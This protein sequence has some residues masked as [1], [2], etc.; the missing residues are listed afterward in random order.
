M[1]HSLQQPHSGDRPP[2]WVVVLSTDNLMEA[3]VVAGRLKSEGID[4]WVQQEPGGS[5]FGITVGIL[6]E[7]RVLVREHD[8]EAARRVLDTPTPPELESDTSHTT[9]VLPDDETSDTDDDE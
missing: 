9:Y 5:A 6:G 4:S 2:Q 1:S 3:H 7:V 8:Y